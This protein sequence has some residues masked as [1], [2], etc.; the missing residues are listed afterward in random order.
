MR[1]KPTNYSFNL[2]IIDASSY[3]FLQYMA[4]WAV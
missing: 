3:M 1:E 4:Q 2:L